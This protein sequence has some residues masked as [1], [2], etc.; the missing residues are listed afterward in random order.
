MFRYPCSY[1][2]HS[3]SFDALP[4][5]MMEYVARRFD[6]VLSGKDESKEFAHLSVADRRGIREILVDTKPDLA[7]RWSRVAAG[8]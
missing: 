1:L 5:R 3:P 4:E 6:E 2:V 8:R 7:H